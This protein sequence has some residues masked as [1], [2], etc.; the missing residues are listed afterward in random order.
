M[1]HRRIRAHYEQLSEFERGHIIGLKERRIPLCPDD[2]RRR[3]WKQPGQ[4]ADPA[5]TIASHT[6]PQQGVMV[7]GA[8]SFEAGLLR[9]SL[10]A[11]LQFCYRSFCNTVTSFFSTIMP[12]PIPYACCYELSYSL[13]STSL[14]SQIAIS[15]SNRACLGYDGKVN[16]SSRKC[17]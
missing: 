16:A 12:N 14:A 5:F 4:R 10:E 9:S 3:V 8:I 11:H 1:P 6:G 15:L 7:W 2:H 17:Q 13:S